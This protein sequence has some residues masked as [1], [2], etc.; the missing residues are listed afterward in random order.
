MHSNDNRW[1]R[2]GLHRVLGMVL[3]AGLAWA[4]AGV[5]WAG[6]AHTVSVTATGGALSAGVV[7]DDLTASVS[8]DVADPPDVTDETTISGPVWTWSVVDAQWFN[9]AA[10]AFE[11]SSYYTVFFDNDDDS[12]QPNATIHVT[13]LRSGTWDITV[14]AAVHYSQPCADGS[15]DTWDGSGLADVTGTVTLGSVDIQAARN[16]T[17]QFGHSAKIAAGGM[18]PGEH[19]ADVQVTV[20]NSANQPVPGAWVDPLHLSGANGVSVAGAL[21]PTLLV[22]GTTDSTGKLVVLKGYHSSDYTAD[23]PSLTL[24]TGSASIAQAWNEAQGTGLDWQLAPDMLVG[25]SAQLTFAPQF[26]GAVPITG[27]TMQF[28]VSAASVTSYDDNG[29]PQTYSYQC[30][31]ATQPNYMDPTS[32][33]FLE[34]ETVTDEET[35]LN[36]GLY[37]GLYTTNVILWDPYADVTFYALDLDVY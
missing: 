5:A 36:T 30:A 32:L 14:Q 20:T 26:D 24:G 31:D 37:T 17:G 11:A 4:G 28:S 1:R 35:G 33:A 6:T 7:G 19:Y 22:G 29:N 10:Q 3:M 2:I 9:P 15:F 18:T 34:D 21:N 12:S 16:G 25:I 8:A 27:H 13:L 23:A